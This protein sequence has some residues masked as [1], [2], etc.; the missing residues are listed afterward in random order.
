MEMPAFMTWVIDHLMS[1]KEDVAEIKA[2]L[3]AGDE[4]MERIEQGQKA[5]RIEPPQ[6]AIAAALAFA[7]EVATPREWTAGAALVGLWVKGIVDA[8]QI[9]T[10]ILTAF[11]VI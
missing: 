5:G 6:S 10:L 7:R 11:G 8:A 3:V 9:K 4:R 1:I 2:Q